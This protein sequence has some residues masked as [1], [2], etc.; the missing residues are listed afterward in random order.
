M[1]FSRLLSYSDEKLKNVE[2]IWK[3]LPDRYFK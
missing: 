1:H 3:S 2:N